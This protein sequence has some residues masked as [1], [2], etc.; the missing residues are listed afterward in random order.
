MTNK[1]KKQKHNFTSQ[2]AS[3]F[4]HRIR[5]APGALPSDRMRHH[6]GS[7]IPSVAQISVQGKEYGAFLGDSPTNSH[8]KQNLADISNAL[9]DFQEQILL[10]I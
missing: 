5:L 3:L 9:T 7:V 6:P 10:K 2:I 1:K 4:L 8:R